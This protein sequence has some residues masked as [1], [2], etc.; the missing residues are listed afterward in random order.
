MATK[1]AKPNGQFQLN[2]EEASAYMSKLLISELPG[3]GSSTTHTLK[4]AHL[5]TCSDLQNISLLR[6]QLLV[7]KKL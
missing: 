1:K 2:S 5:I 4:E 6:L 3:V 7:G